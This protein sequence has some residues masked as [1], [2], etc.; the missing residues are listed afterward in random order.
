MNADEK[1]YLFQH[2]A[3]TNEYQIP[4]EVKF[5]KQDFTLSPNQDFSFN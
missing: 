3:L 5:Q 1:M 2:L 4:T